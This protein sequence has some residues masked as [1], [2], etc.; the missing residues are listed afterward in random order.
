VDKRNE[1]D[2]DLQSAGWTV[3]HFTGRQVLRNPES[4]VA[5][6]HGAICDSH[7]QSNRG[8]RG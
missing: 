4:C 8:D 6:V 7:A 1:R 5:R 3:V 2:L